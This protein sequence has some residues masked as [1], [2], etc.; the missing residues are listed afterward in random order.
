MDEKEKWDKNII[1]LWLFFLPLNTPSQRVH[2]LTGPK[3]WGARG[4]KRTFF[5]SEHFRSASETISITYIPMKEKINLSIHFYSNLRYVL[6]I[7]SEKLTP[8]IFFSETKPRDILNSLALWFCQAMLRQTS[9]CNRRVMDSLLEQ[10]YSRGSIA[11][12][13]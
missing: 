7:P 6:H 11:R 5:P 12:S 8:L 10:T 1:T 13:S 4:R 2:W 9:A 3:F